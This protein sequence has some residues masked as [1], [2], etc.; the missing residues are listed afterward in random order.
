MGERE[1]HPGAARSAR[2]TRSS[3]RCSPA[4]GKISL[5]LRPG[6]A[7]AGAGAALRGRRRRRRPV[8]LKTLQ[9]GRASAGAG[10]APRGRRRRRRRVRLKTSLL[11]LG[12]QQHPLLLGLGNQYVIGPRDSNTP[13]PAPKTT[14]KLLGL[15]IQK[16]TFPAPKATGP[17]HAVR[18][19]LHA[20]REGRHPRDISLLGLGIRYHPPLHRRRHD[21]SDD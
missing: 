9:P 18:L 4:T 12:I 5:T 14:R 2:A 19:P 16:K 11:G 15:G 17:Y 10:A 21:T 7:R 20:D 6:R 8:R 3:P 1:A 13:F